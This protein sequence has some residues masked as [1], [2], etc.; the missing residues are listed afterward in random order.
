M[1][2]NKVPAEGIVVKLEE[3][4]SCRPTKLKSFNFLEYETKQLDNDEK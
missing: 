1:C 3:L 2:K 4:F